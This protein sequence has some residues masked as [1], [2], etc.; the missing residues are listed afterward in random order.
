[1]R[2]EEKRGGTRGRRSERRR[3]R[4]MTVTGG[5]SHLNACP[6]LRSVATRHTLNS[7]V[8][9]PLV[10]PGALASDESEP[11]APLRGGGARADVS[12]GATRL[13]ERAPG[14]K[15]SPARA[16]TRPLV[17]DGPH[18]GARGA[19]TCG[20]G[21][22]NVNLPRPC[23]GT[24]AELVPRVTSL[25]SSW[26]RPKS[27]YPTARP[28]LTDTRP[29]LATSSAR[30]PI[31][32]R[33]CVTFATHLGLIIHKV[34]Q[35]L[36]TRR[37]SLDALA[38]SFILRLALRPPPLASLSLETLERSCSICGHLCL[39]DWPWFPAGDNALAPRRW[40][41]RLDVGLLVTLAAAAVHERARLLQRWGEH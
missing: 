2:V 29:A 14:S 33:R 7:S 9:P 20:H 16:A 15:C 25:R 23:T 34:P 10:P 36:R 19:P 22:L 5:Q 21:R 40:S 3:P 35:R 13:C 30:P 41:G 17:P 37:Q 27:P 28:P 8:L 18:R 39:P 24:A 6:V 4:G 11:R 1:M 38:L 32:R 12:G 31:S 26:T